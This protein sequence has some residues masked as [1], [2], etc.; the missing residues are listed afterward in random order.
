MKGERERNGRVGEKG[1]DLHIAGEEN[2][3]LGGKYIGV[4]GKGS[5]REWN[6]IILN[7]SEV[8]GIKE[9]YIA[10]KGKRKVSYGK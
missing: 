8:Y 3:R 7:T 1:R 2:A 9:R 5:I 6:H 10:E 4:Y